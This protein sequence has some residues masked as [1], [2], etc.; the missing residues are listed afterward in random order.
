MTVRKDLYRTYNIQIFESGS[1]AMVGGWL[2]V[3]EN[4][5]EKTCIKPTEVFA[6]QTIP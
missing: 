6:T 5:G 2:A 3:P 4:K 1:M